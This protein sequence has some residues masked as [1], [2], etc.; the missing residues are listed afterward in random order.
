MNQTF[1][2]PGKLPGMNEILRLKGAG[3]R[4]GNF[5]YNAMKKKI[6]RQVWGEVRK[7]KIDPVA[8]ARMDFLWVEP[9]RKR[10]KDNI[11]AARKFVLD[12]LVEAGVLQGDGWKYIDG[13]TDEFRVDKEKPGVKVTIFEV[14]GG[15]K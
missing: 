2:L 10:D 14:K 8:C 7:R 13:W 9:N 6:H 3:R 12:G 1:F 5:G 15:C 11:C 4:G